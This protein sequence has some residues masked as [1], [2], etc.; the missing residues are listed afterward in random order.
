MLT[1]SDHWGYS[2]RDEDFGTELVDSNGVV[3]TIGNQVGKGSTS[4]TTTYT[5]EVIAC[6]HKGYAKKLGDYQAYDCMDIDGIHDWSVRNS[7]TWTDWDAERR[8]KA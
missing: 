5:Y 3:W 6:T 2:E 4:M 1:A 7:E 8:K